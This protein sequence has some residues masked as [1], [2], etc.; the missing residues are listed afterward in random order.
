MKGAG[1]I[2]CIG[3]TCSTRVGKLL[4]RYAGESDMKP[5]GWSAVAKARSPVR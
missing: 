3:F 5:S 1:D 2:E 4:R